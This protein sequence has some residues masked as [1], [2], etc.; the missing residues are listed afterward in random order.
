MNKSNSSVFIRQADFIALDNKEVIE[1][2]V[3]LSSKKL[4]S[5]IKVEGVQGMIILD[6]FVAA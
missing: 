2:T 3:D 1:E 5:W 4:T 6:D